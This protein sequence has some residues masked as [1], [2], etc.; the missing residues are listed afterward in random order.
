[1]LLYRPDMRV[2]DAAQMREAER[3]TI[4]AIGIPAIVLM[5]NAGQRV[6]D[7]MASVFDDLEADRVA[8]LC[9]RGNNGGDGFVVARA[10]RQRG[11]SVTVFLLGRAADVRGAARTNLDVLGGVG[12]PVVEMADAGAW[13]GCAREVLAHDL[14]VDALYGTGLNRP[15]GATAAAVVAGVNAAPVP[16]VAVDVPSGLLADSHEVRGPAI[17]ADVTVTFAAPKIPLVLQPACEAAGDIYVADIGIPE[18]AI[19]AAPGPRLDLLTPPAVRAHMPRRDAE[20]HK[21]TFGHVLLV[22]GSLGRTGAARLA[23]GGA[24]RSGAGLVTVATPRACVASVAAGAPEYMTLPLAEDGEGVVGA[25]A[26][27]AVLAAQCDVIAAGPGLGV[28]PGAAAL[29]RGLIERAEAPLVLDADALNV[30]AGH[31][32]WFRARRADVVLTPHPGEMARL[33]GRPAADVQADRLACARALAAEH[34]VYVVLKGARTLVVGPAGSAA[35]NLTGNPGLASGGAG[36][37]LTGVVAAWIGVL[38]RTLEACQVAVHLHGR[39]A[40]IAAGEQ[41]EAALIAS[42]VVAALGQAQRETLDPQS[43]GSRDDTHRA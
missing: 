39:A 15:L 4:E 31:L 10:L 36:D 43:I 2:L 34:C 8:V 21:G 14:L 33:C 30:C 32:E 3:R 19:D 25:E 26:L 18:A 28:G 23:G 17:E 40:D 20:A 6:V 12:V 1:M 7:V 5:E 37:V 13:A 27:D 11:A 41:G 29:V 16:V 9:G 38:G 22:A 35:V 24:L 42:D